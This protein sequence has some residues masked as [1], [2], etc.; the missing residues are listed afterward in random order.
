MKKGV[1]YQSGSM[2]T[3][4]E[5]EIA[6]LIGFLKTVARTL[7]ISGLT[8]IFLTT[9]NLM[10]ILWPVGWAE[11]RYGVSNIKL[12]KQFRKV[13]SQKQGRNFLTVTVPDVAPKPTPAPAKPTWEVPDNNYSVF[14]PKLAATSRVISDVDPGDAKQYMEALKLGVA[15]ARDLAHPGQMGTTYLFAHS[16]GSRADY[17][18]YNA[19]FY[20]LD[21]L[22]EGDKVEVVY[23]EKL[24]KYVV[25]KRE[26]LPP[27]D[28]RYLLPQQDEEL[29]VLQTCYPPGTTWKRLMVVAKPVI[30]K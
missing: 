6:K 23:R 18:R 10:A 8:L 1:V 28:I 21:K 24:F 5:V 12:V 17:A 19:V 2:S 16:V 13:Q 30:S 11:V 29:L 4:G 3:S 26:I 15:E 22:V 20:L 27:D 14:I 9:V 25:E 7:M